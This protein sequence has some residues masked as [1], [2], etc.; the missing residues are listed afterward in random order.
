MGYWQFAKM[1]GNA[2]IN[3]V[4]DL[5]Q[6]MNVSKDMKGIV[7]MSFGFPMTEAELAQH[8]E[9]F[10]ELKEYITQNGG[11]IK[12]VKIKESSVDNRNNA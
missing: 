11:S 8:T 4:I 10:E 3:E 12:E 7:Q 1:N 2:T 5:L 9:N 6:R